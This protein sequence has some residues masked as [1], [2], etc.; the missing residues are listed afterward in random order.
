[1]DMGTPLNVVLASVDPI[2]RR[3]ILSLP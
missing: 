1:V 2:L 3:M